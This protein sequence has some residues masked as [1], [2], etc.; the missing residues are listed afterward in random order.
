MLLYIDY[1]IF[2]KED[3]LG[4]ASKDKFHYLPDLGDLP[5]LD[6]PMELPLLPGILSFLEFQYYR[7][8]MTGTSDNHQLYT[9][10]HLY[11]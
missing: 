9:I 3:Y 1:V 7:L 10:I 6:L 4:V 8:P 2:Q 5:E 11:Q